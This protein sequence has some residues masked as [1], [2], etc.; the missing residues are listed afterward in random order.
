MPLAEG[1][2]HREKVVREVKRAGAPWPRLRRRLRPTPNA[3]G[4]H[5]RPIEAPVAFRLCRPVEEGR[6]RPLAWHPRR[7]PPIRS[8]PRLGFDL[9]PRAPR[10]SAGRRSP[11]RT[12]PPR[13][14]PEDLLSPPGARRRKERGG[15]GGRPADIPPIIARGTAAARSGAARTDR[16]A[17]RSGMMDRYRQQGSWTGSPQYMRGISSEKARGRK[18][19]SSSRWSQAGRAAEQPASRRT[20]SRSAPQEP[21]TSA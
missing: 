19:S 1:V 2:L 18:H 21:P 16:V 12:P 13:R 15:G 10:V 5:R 14:S 3:R 8:Q 9:A 6:E 4:P 20:P 7:D 11:I 17:H